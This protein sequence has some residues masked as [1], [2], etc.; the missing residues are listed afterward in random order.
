ME[1]TAVKTFEAACTI[2]FKGFD[3]AR[4]GDHVARVLGEALGASLA[5]SLAPALAI[6]G[7][8]ASVEASVTV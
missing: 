6:I 7:N 3:A 5:A 1:T 2:K 8:E 4:D